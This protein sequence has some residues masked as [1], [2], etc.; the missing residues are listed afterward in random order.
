M[1]GA[2]PSTSTTSNAPVFCPS[3][4]SALIELTMVIGMC[5]VNS[6][7]KLSAWSK[8]PRICKTWAPYTIACASFPREIFPSG[9]KTTQSMPALAAYAAA[10]AEVFP[11][12]PQITVFAPLAFAWVTALV[13][14]RSLKEPDG[15]SPSNF[16][17]TS[18][19]SRSER[20][21]ARISGVLPS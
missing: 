12:D 8:L 4:R 7:A 15:L 20:R 10:A 21:S 9:T 17:H 19:S 11:V 14:P 5:C 16:S 1:S 13:I 2:F 18:A 3:I 6:R